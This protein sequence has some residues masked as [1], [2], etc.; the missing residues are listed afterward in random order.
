MLNKRGPRTEPCGTPD[1]NSD[2]ELKV[3]QIL[4]LCHLFVK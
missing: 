4:V 3:V 2:Q 1:S